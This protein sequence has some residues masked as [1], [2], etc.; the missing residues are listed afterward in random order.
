MP[1]PLGQT[2]RFR[3]LPL[4]FTALAISAAIA[5]IAYAVFAA[6]EHDAWFPRE[7]SR[8]LN[9]NEAAV[10]A[11]GALVLALVI[12]TIFYRL[13]AFSGSSGPGQG[14]D[15]GP[16]P[17]QWPSAPS[18]GSTPAAAFETP[19]PVSIGLR[20]DG[21]APRIPV[22]MQRERR[23]CT[24]DLVLSE[25]RLYFICYSDQSLAK[26]N[27]GKIAASQFG[28]LG[29]LIQALISSKS[30]KRSAEQ[31]AQKRREYS[32]YS[33]DEQASRSSFSLTLAPREITLI[34][35]SSLTGTRI[36]A[37]GKKYPL[38]DFDRKLL[39]PLGDWCKNHGVETKGF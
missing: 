13:G 3:H 28:L 24:G 17:G 30:K 12:G 20:H 32:A 18:A 16:E 29:A 4:W 19:A 11:G 37:G 1:N 27:A 9:H 38:I 15:G 31:L 34:S 14:W 10:F 5:G 35:S 23:A 25:R 39:G 26:A 33:L 36:E 6:Y 21:T 22:V 8:F 2:R 7:L